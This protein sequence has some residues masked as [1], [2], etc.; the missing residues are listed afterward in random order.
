MSELPQVWQPSAFQGADLLPKPVAPQD[1]DEPLVGRDN[2]SQTDLILPSLR[3]L[4]G[5]SP[6]VTEGQIEAA[7]PGLILHTGTREV[8]KPPMRLL[9]VHHSKSNFL[10]PDPKNPRHAGLEKCMARDAMHGDRYG[11]C[12]ECKKCTEW[13]A[14]GGKPL[15]S[16]SHNFVA[17]TPFGPAV[18]RFGRTSFKAARE[19]VTT[20]TMGN[21]NLWAHPVVVR[22][23]SQQRTLDNG[24]QATYFVWEPLW[25]TSEE[26]PKSM[27]LAAREMHDMVDA[28]HKAGRFSSDDEDDT[29]PLE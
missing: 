14:D 11:Y 9:F 28:A 3:L 8:L 20:W 12:D 21:K 25:Q 4:Q 6:A 15:G 29:D 26:V 1:D 2:V 10:A 22:V 23:K 19:F 24:Q 17:M 27:R 7:R 5:M 13:P 18:V 16:Q